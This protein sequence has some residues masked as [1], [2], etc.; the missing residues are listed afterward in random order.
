MSCLAEIKVFI[1]R[2]FGL[3]IRVCINLASEQKAAI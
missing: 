2:E 1:D 3:G